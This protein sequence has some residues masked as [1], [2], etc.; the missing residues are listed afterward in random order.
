MFGRC[1]LVFLA[2]TQPNRAEVQHNSEV[3]L[4][5]RNTEIRNSRKY[6]KKYSEWNITN[7]ASSYAVFHSKEQK[8]K[9]VMLD[10]PIITRA[11]S[12]DVRSLGDFS[13]E[14]REVFVEF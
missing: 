6:N 4:T 14:S 12:S 10:W 9:G 11:L 8:A 13:K 1:F 5:R 2:G 3:N 7:E